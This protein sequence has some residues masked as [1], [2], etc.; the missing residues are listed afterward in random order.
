[1][2]DPHDLGAYAR[3][4]YYDEKKKGND[5]TMPLVLMGGATVCVGLIMLKSAY[6][7]MHGRPRSGF[8][9]Y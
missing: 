3:H 9:R 8:S 1:M 7:K 4:I 2:I 6:D 5:T